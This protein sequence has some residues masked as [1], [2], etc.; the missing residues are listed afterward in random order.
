M[1]VEARKAAAQYNTAIG[2]TVNFENDAC[3]AAELRLPPGGGDELDI[4]QHTLD[5][6]LAFLRLDAK[7][8]LHANLRGCLS[9]GLAHTFC[10]GQ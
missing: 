5:Y 4:H 10:S 3:R 9:V 7:P 8:H 1:E 2:T 6:G